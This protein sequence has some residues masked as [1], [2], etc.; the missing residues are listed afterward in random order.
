[1]LSHSFFRLAPAKFVGVQDGC[2]V[3]PSFELFN[4]EAPVG[5]HPQG[6]TVSRSTLE[7][8][9]FF[10]PSTD[11]QLDSEIR[12]EQEPNDSTPLWGM[13]TV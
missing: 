13:A 1:M 9:G 6:S 11:A 3:R 2:G 4:L 8:H 10:V 12:N 7:S 5:D